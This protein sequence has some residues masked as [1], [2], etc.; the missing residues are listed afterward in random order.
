ML[1]ISLR[2]S[3]LL[4]ISRINIQNYRS[5]KEAQIDIPYDPSNG[6]TITLFSGR[7][8]AGK[9]SLF[10]SIGWCLTGKESQELLGSKSHEKTIPRDSEFDQEGNNSVS[11]EID[12][13]SPENPERRRLIIKRREI[14]KKNVVE[15]VYSEVSIDT[16][17][18]KDVQT[19]S[20]LSENENVKIQ[21]ILN[22][23]FPELLSRFH[24]FDG[25][26]LV[27]TYSE[28]GTN[29][30]GAL[31]GMFKIGAL[32]RLN[33]VLS[34][35]WGEYSHK[36]GRMKQD[37]KLSKL[38]A[39][40]EETSKHLSDTKNRLI[41]AEEE[42]TTLDEEIKILDEEIASLA[43]EKGKAK[44]KEQMHKSLERLKAE[45]AGVDKDLEKIKLSLWK[46]ILTVSP[47][48]NLKPEMSV[49]SGLI[50]KA[51]KTGDIPPKIKETFIKDLLTNKRCICGTILEPGTDAYSHIHTYLEEG[52]NSE[53]RIVLL[54]LRPLLDHNL[55]EVKGEFEIINSKIDEI[56]R[57]LERADY[58]DK[59][60]D[61]LININFDEVSKGIIK[62]FE[63]KSSERGAK[64]I[65]RDK[66]RDLANDLR[67]REKGFSED[68]RILMEKI[69][70]ESGKLDGLG[71]I[72]KMMD[73]T[74][75]LQAIFNGIPEMLLE[76][77]ASKI[78][79]YSNDL[80][81]QIPE[82]KGKVAK[83]EI[84]PQRKLDFHLEQNG[85][86]AYLTGGESQIA[87][88]LL[89]ASFIKIVKDLREYLNVPFICMD[90]PFSNYD[91]QA[92]ITMPQRLSNMFSGAQ[93]ILFLPDTEYIDFAKNANST[94]A[95]AY[96]LEK[97][98]HG[99]T[100]VKEMIP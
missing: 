19:L 23:I 8:G 90:H 58:L 31:K 84:L 10:N 34:E 47:K 11:V 28:R 44:E 89:I 30:E 27:Q 73:T 38:N 24:L 45:R 54:E 6:K 48:L 49:S 72:N 56:N 51:E 52:R 15:A 98:N 9:T 3:E 64:A 91:T 39:D 96:W 26:F 99:E 85:G 94:M 86:I 7:I 36:I 97:N 71:E 78:E 2:R 93:I 95:K 13:M 16:Y 18:Q 32:V 12:I 83:V 42:I 70:E 79:N 68:I 81:G 76:E 69:S 22:E 100:E 59:E 37:K 41:V 75:K 62:K 60:M 50:T 1:K 35:I 14:Y 20:S 82:L 21:S 33:Q 67:R 57:F 29:I 65:L 61:S 63:L 46:Y 88:K 4:Y 74:S 40:Y 77:F 25:E 53:R 55:N 92:K 5:W 17:G 87:G 66:R 80:I 43:E